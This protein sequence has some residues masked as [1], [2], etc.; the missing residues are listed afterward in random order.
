VN[1]G[2]TTEL[3]TYISVLDGRTVDEATVLRWHPLVDDLD[4]ELAKAAVDLHDRENPGWIKPADVRRNVGRILDAAE[5]P[6]DDYGNPLPPDVE[7]LRVRARLAT[8][9]R[10]RAVTS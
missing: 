4:L 8:M 9:P 3:L 7:A 6:E 2:E 1:I 10:R 5:L